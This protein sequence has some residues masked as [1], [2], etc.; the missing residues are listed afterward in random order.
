MNDACLRISPG[1]PSWPHAPVDLRSVVTDFLSEC[2]I[3]FLPTF[4]GSNPFRSIPYR[5]TPY[6]SIPS[7]FPGRSRRNPSYLMGYPRYRR[8][9]SRSF[10]FHSAT[11][12]S[13]TS[14][15]SRYLSIPESLGWTAWNLPSFRVCSW[16]RSWS[17]SFP[18]RQRLR[19][20]C[21]RRPGRR[22][23]HPGASPSCP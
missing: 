16:F 15:W 6:P 19:W 22:P 21:P 7:P 18:R 8:D 12:P 20:K 5:L 23:P 11:F 1:I 14:L 4:P 17:R 2:W 3:R 13:A 10:R 9:C